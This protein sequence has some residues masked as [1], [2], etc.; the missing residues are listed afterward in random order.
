MR[1]QY[2][3]SLVELMISITIGLILM[4]GVIQL[5]LSSRATFSTQQAVA[6]V[7]ETG[8]LAMEFLSSDARMAGYMGCMSRNA[9]IS[10]MLNTPNSL[11]YDYATPLEG[12]D[13]ATGTLEAG[14]PTNVLAGTDVLLV[15]SASGTAVGVAAPNT[16]TAVLAEFTNSAVTCADNSAGVSGFCPS[17]IV[18]VSDCTKARVFQVSGA[19][20]ASGNTHTILDHGA[21]SSP[22]NATVT[23][24]GASATGLYETFDTDAEIA[25]LNTTIYYISDQGASGVPGLWQRVNGGNAQ[26]L[27]EGVEDMQILYG[28]DTGSDGVPDDY[29]TA[30]AV[31]AAWD[32]VTSV[33][34]QLLVRS[35]EN[36]VL[37]E[38]QPYTF[39]GATTTPA[40]RRL[41]QVFS[42]TIG[43]RSNLQ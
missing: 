13:N 25:K 26:E 8:R 28:R 9:N 40:D 14:Y 6:R 15:R 22:G 17:D 33:R 37:A 35:G 30:T 16:G 19:A 39:N 1:K 21:G 38:A 12:V 4:T 11:L 20:A 7:Q 29:L 41:R 3:I 42:S 23:W 31:G 10:N 2:G 18:V 27:L 32:Q 24:G 43:I 34:I 5:F 36:N